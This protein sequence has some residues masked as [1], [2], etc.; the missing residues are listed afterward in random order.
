MFACVQESN[1]D[2]GAGVDACLQ[3]DD[4]DGGDGYMH[5]YRMMIIMVVMGICMCTGC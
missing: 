1:D 2:G 5:A 4:A 3:D